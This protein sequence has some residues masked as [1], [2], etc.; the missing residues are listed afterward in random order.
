MS[1]VWLDLSSSVQVADMPGEFGCHRRGSGVGQVEVD[2]E[3]SELGN[4]VLFLVRRQRS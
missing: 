2:P 1:P 3:L 4:T